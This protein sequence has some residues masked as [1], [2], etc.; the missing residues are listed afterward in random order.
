MFF[1]KALF[2]DK[3]IFVNKLTFKQGVQRIMLNEDLRKTAISRYLQGERPSDIC[4]DLNK[5][6]TWF[7]K[8]LNRYKTGSSKWFKAKSRKPIHQPR[9]TPQAEEEVI[10]NIRKRLESIKYAQIGANVI[11]WEMKK[12]GLSP[13]PIWT[14]NRILKRHNLVKKRRKQYIPKGKAYPSLDS[15]QL[16]YLQQIDVVGPRYIAGDGRFYTHNLIDVTTHQISLYPS[17]D[18]QDSSVV[19]ALI[20]AWKTLGIPEYLQMDNALYYR[21]SNRYPRSFG[22]VIRFCLHLDVQPVF[23]PIR[24]PWRQGVI[25]QFNNVY[26]K[27]FFNIQKFISFENLA[28]ETFIFER[29]H[30]ENHVYTVLKGIPP[31]RFVLENEYNPVR[32]DAQYELPDTIPLAIGKI[33]LIRFIKSDRCLNVFGEKFSLKEMPPY[34]YATAIIHTHEHKISVY[35]DKEL[36]E[37]IDYPIPLN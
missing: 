14:I 13:L 9:K 26:D 22:L 34:E 30:N 32:L 16:G 24:E 27:K 15:A 33:R 4:K 11:Q 28:Q 29:F 6:R 10:I 18:Q 20:K 8:W 31:N 35:F 21:G 19:H 3:H 37:E 17:R 2:F 7:Y 23:V 5:S 25:E 1:D 36:I 12:L